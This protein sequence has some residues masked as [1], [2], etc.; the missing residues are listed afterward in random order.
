MHETVHNIITHVYW[1]VGIYRDILR[2]YRD[3]LGIYRD[4]LGYT[5]IL[6]P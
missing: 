6:S 5:G 1:E 4:I 3:I 2:I